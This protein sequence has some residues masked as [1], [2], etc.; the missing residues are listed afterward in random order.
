MDYVQGT[1]NY[2]MHLALNYKNKP[3]I[4]IVLIPERDELWISTGS[5]VWCENRAGVKKEA[6]LSNNKILNDMTIVTSKNH[7]NEIL[8]KLIKLVNFKNCCNG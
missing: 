7:K 6:R 1:G 5:K 2:A 3:Y 4:G 8:N